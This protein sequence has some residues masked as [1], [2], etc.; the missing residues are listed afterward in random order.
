MRLEENELWIGK[1]LKGG[2]RVL[3]EGALSA[4]A[5]ETEGNHKEILVW[6]V[7]NPAGT[8]FGTGEQIISAKVGLRPT[9]DLAGLMQPSVAILFINAELN[10]NLINLKYCST[11]WEN[12]FN[13]CDSCDSKQTNHTFT[14]YSPYA[15][16][17]ISRASCWKGVSAH[18]HN[19]KYLV[20]VRC[21][22][23]QKGVMLVLL[24]TKIET[25]TFQR[26]DTNNAHLSNQVSV[27]T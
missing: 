22:S 27:R 11:L 6:T 23:C 10:S 19:R 9:E 26:M 25:V 12:R 21:M 20:I 8:L 24:Y 2:D 18:L 4:F 15:I 16:F 17:T 1:D 3:F 14:P 13:F 5:R 7:G